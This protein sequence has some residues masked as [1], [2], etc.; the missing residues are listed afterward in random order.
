ME[1]ME[2][3][4]FFKDT[5]E[6]EMMA[7]TPP[8]DE[9]DHHKEDHHKDKKGCCEDLTHVIDG[10]DEYKEVGSVSMPNLQFIAVLYAVAFDFF[11][12]S[13]LDN[14]PYKE[15]SPPTIERDIPV[16]VQSFLI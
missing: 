13:V 2:S 9:E 15:Y 10:Q 12:T 7:K 5:Q 3:I 4:A 11:A 1:Q 14:Y 16:L 8:C 6:C